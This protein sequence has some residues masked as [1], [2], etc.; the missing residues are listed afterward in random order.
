T[1]PATCGCR[2]RADWPSSR[3][4][5]GCT[6]PPIPERTTMAETLA[7]PRGGLFTK[8]EAPVPLAGVAIDAEVSTLCARVTVTQRYV[9]R[10]AKPIEAVYVFPLDEGA[11]VCGFEAI[12]DGTLVIGEVHEREAAFEMYDDAIQKGHGA[13][14]LE[15]ERPDVFQASVGNL[16]PGKEVLL[17]LTYVTE[18]SIAGSAVRFA[19]PTTVS[20][21]Y[22]PAGD[23]GG[24]GR[25]DSE[26]L[27]PPVAWRVPY[28]LDLTVRVRMGGAIARIESPSHT[29]AV[30]MNGQSAT[31]TLSQRDAALDR[32]FVLSVES[33]ALDAP[34]GWIEKDDD[35]TEAVAIAFVPVLPGTSVPAEIVFL[36]D[37]SGSMAGASIAEVRN[38]LQTCL[39][40]MTAGCAFNIVGF[41]S[42]FEPLFKASRAYDERSLAEANTNVAALDANL[43]GTEILPALKYVLEQGR[44]G[45][46]PRQVVVLTDGQVTNTDAVLALAAEH[47]S[48]ARIFTFGIGAS[49]SHHLVKGLA[50]AG[51]GVAELIHPGERIEAKV[52]RQF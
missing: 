15:E 33:A 49:A 9:N 30:S 1:S 32:D 6:F 13:Y 46:L 29:V 31:V 12:I 17:R 24:V 3:R 11:A 40:S 5:V 47:A 43:G 44:H 26:T 20:P 23:H 2:R 4:G 22:A 34:R 21:R 28:G 36:V 52:L 42:T 51:G 8:D 50:R 39:R 37:R 10:E 14:L 41:G 19:I 7:A 18:L 45:A 25:P 35:G 38:A 48:T 16:P 27:N